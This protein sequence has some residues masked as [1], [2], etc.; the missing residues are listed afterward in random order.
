MLTI[1][2][3]VQCGNSAYLT[4]IRVQILPWPF[5]LGLHD[6]LEQ[7]RICAS[8]LWK[9][10]ASHSLP[11][12]FK[13]AFNLKINPVFL[14]FNFCHLRP[15]IEEFLHWRLPLGSGSSQFLYLVCMQD[16]EHLP[17]RLHRPQFPFAGM[18]KLLRGERRGE[19]EL[20]DSLEKLM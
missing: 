18:F 9:C 15:L 2:S 11:P 7:L 10:S 19:L 14:L 13:K 4:N 3:P 8:Y 16:L 20:R 1:F 5:T 12:F 6:P 17:H